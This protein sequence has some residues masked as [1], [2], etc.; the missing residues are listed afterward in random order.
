MDGDCVKI[1]G[2][3]KKRGNFIK[4]IGLVCLAGFSL[5]ALYLA[6]LIKDLPR[7]EEFGSKQIS[8]STKIYDRTG[9]TLLYEIHGEEKRT[10]VDF[11]TIPVYLKS[12]ILTAE[13]ANFYHQPAFDW[14]A[15]I[16]ALVKNLKAGRVTQGGST[17]TQQL[18]KNLF[19]T[20]EKTISRKI[21]EIILALELE[22]K[23]SKD[24]IFE[25]YLNQIAFGSSAYGVEAASQIYFNKTI[26]DLNPAEAAVLASLIKAPSYYSPWGSHQSELFDRQS[27]VLNRM[28]ELG[29]INESE[30]NAAQEQTKKIKFAV[31]PTGGAIKA[32]HFVF[33]VKDYLV[34]KY[35]EEVVEKGGLKVF[36]TLDWNMQQ[37]AEQT[38]AAGVERNKQLYDGNNGALIAQDP[39]TG[40]VLALVGSKDYFDVVNEGNFNVAAQGL[41]Q[42]GSALKPFV[43]LTAFKK[44]YSPKTVVFDVE[45]EFD[46]TNNPEKSY[47]PQNFDNYFRG[48]VLLEQAL[49]QSINVPSV[50]V[51]YLAGIDDVLKTVHDFGV[52]TLQ[53]RARYGL[54]LVLGGGEV[55]LMDLVGA[56]SV[57][58]ADGI[59]HKQSLILKIEDAKGNLVE[60]FQDETLRVSDE[61]LIRTV[62]QILSDEN[63]RS[64]LF[65]Q[66]FGLTVFPG[67]EIALKTGTTN[68]YRDAW[69][70][71]YTPF[72]TAGVWAGNNDNRT[73]QR[74]GSSIL[75]A[76]P[77]WHDF[78]AR[79]LEKYSP[80]TFIKPEP[81]V[82]PQ[83]SMLNGEVVFSPIIN[84]VAKPQIHSILYYVNKDDPLG[85]IPTDPFQD[86]QFVN[87]ENGVLNWARTNL[88]NF[89]TYNTQIPY[90]VLNQN[91]PQNSSSEEVGQNKNIVIN[92]TQPRNG[93][94][95]STP[96]MV[97]AQLQANQRLTMVEF[98]FNRL[99]FDRRT[100]NG[101][102]YNYEYPLFGLNSQN[103]IEIKA[104]DQTGS[105]N[106][107][108]IIVFH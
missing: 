74:Q 87:W 105:S 79:I 3:K 52:T 59:K 103:L 72:L 98:Y 70:M 77:I 13:D 33:M 15:I 8:Q 42:P 30:L 66:S 99:L 22:S 12:A 48:P 2:L 21:R 78:M 68:D 106:K 16:R 11:E 19:L 23:Y 43:Y 69:A 37:I 10:V 5:A 39:K 34:T 97:K 47:K 38:V 32:P 58:A 6:W 4:F 73:M 94:F 90:E 14:K 27:Y 35:G 107:S 9:Q 45:T 1:M 29:F 81:V 83:K 54:S 76:V 89:Y 80:E 96:L 25:L 75:A 108:S 64:G 104:F 60:E 40:Q 26:K 7:P 61:Q 93:E 85:P 24:Q 55:K 102:F 84:G 31:Q 82:Y 88:P 65:Q 28:K 17:I 57:F 63:L 56:Y 49:A 18:A 51:L 86:Y 95:V 62:N 50:K 101:S 92:I 44:G 20:P 67:Y 71:G 41:R 36:T 46:T 91:A 100:I 53:E